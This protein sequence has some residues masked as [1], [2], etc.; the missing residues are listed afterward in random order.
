MV[1]II[2]GRYYKTR[3]G[4]KVGPMV[5]HEYGWTADEGFT[6]YGT[7][8]KR[9]LGF[10]GDEPEDLISEWGEGPVVT[11]TVKR[12]VDWSGDDV[13]VSV[14]PDGKIL[15]DVRMLTRKPER[16]KSAIAVLTQLAD[17]LEDK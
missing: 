12:I 11:E 10:G 3:G 16:V 9:A 4:R 8:G 1:T 6:I 15:I 13:T 14:H 2:E 17:A 5:Q 7:D